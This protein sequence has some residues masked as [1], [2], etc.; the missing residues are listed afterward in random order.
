VLLLVS[1]FYFG[2]KHYWN[3]RRGVCLDQG[4]VKWSDTGSIA[5]AHPNQVLSFEQQNTNPAAWLV[6]CKCR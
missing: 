3:V 1:I 6:M 2:L 5:C 4:Q